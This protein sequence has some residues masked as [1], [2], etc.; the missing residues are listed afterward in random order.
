MEQVRVTVSGPVFGNFNYLF[1]R[2]RG[3]WLPVFND[4]AVLAAAD[5]QSLLLSL[6]LI[7]S[8]RERRRMACLL[9]LLPAPA[10]A[11][12]PTDSCSR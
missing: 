5:A 1:D 11:L 12:T 8:W 6:D 3:E 2:G 10:R 7:Q 4:E 9:R